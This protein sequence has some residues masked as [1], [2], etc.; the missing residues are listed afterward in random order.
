MK[1]ALLILGA[2]IITFVLATVFFFIGM[3]IGG[4]YFT[5]FEFMGNRGYEATGLIGLFIGLFLGAGLSIV[6]FIYYND[7][8]KKLR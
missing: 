8:E 3:T 6:V 7:D 5:N 4:N 2:I 1:T